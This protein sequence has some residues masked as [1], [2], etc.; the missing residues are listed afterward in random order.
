MHSQAQPVLNARLSGAVYTEDRSF[1]AVYTEEPTTEY[2]EGRI[3]ASISGPELDVPYP[4]KH[5][6]FGG[7]EV[8]N[9]LLAFHKELNPSLYIPQCT[10]AVRE[11]IKNNQF[12]KQ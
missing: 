8:V 4:P 12:L 1:A 3:T 10:N 9:S 2:T 11:E 5:L 7:A 6:D